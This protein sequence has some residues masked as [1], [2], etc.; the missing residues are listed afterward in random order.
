MTATAR[1]IIRAMD[2]QL[3]VAQV[4]TLD[5]V[6]AQSLST[7]RLATTLLGLFGVLA[8]T[9]SAIGV[10]GVMS[11]GVARRTNEIGIRMALGARASDVTRLVVGQGMRPA[12]LGLILGVVVALSGAKLMRGLLFGVSENDPASLVAA[13]GVLGGVA[14]L[15]T[16]IP[17]RRVARVDP[18]SALRSD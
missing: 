8:L 5:D 15:A 14:L 12:I 9:L 4:R 6:V 13:V 16:M 17:A 1:D 10:Y 11:Y 2:P 3:P 7:P 18:V